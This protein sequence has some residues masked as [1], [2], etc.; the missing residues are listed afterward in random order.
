MLNN[1]QSNT[2]TPE[3]YFDTLEDLGHVQIITHPVG[4]FITLALVA[5]RT[6]LNNFLEEGESL[7]SGNLPPATMHR[8]NSLGFKGTPRSSS[9]NRSELPYVVR[10]TTLRAEGQSIHFILDIP[11][12]SI[13][14]YRTNILPSVRF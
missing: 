3:E 11:C 5:D 4:N 8:I 12:N 2:V 14:D 9:I 10:S 6:Q 1:N 13:Q 7:L